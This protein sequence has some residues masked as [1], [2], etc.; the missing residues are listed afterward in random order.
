[1]AEP[2]VVQ[3]I[4]DD[5]VATAGSKIATAQATTST[6][7]T[8]IAT[9]QARIANSVSKLANQDNTPFSDHD[10]WLTI[11]AARCQHPNA[12]ASSFPEAIV[13]AN[14]VLAE[15]KTRFPRTAQEPLSST[16]FLPELN[17]ELFK[18]VTPK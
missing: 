16:G 10:V 3:N 15:F 12:T 6:A 8:G 4:A 2:I 11:V 13:Y 5:R 14:R 9:A 18:P 1:M 7:Q 17:V